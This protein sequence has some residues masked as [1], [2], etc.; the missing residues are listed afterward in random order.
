MSVFG[1]SLDSADVEAAVLAHLRA[2]MPT[3][4]PEIRRQKDPDGKLWPDGVEAIREYTVSHA[5]AVA[6]KW[7]E[8]QLPMLIA[9]SPGMEGDPYEQGDGT[10]SA[11]YGIAVTAIASGATQAD[12][13]ALARL[14]AS[15]A[16]MA[17][18]QEP[19]LAAGTDTPFAGGVAMGAERIAP[20]RRGVEAERNLLA[21]T[22]PFLIEVNEIL[23][24]N[25]GP[26][27]PQTAEEIAEGVEP[28]EWPDVKEGGGSVAIDQGADKVALLREGGFFPD[29]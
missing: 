27:K 5:Q 12:T 2:W 28:P 22:Y 7:P 26:L 17:M 9:E 25:G 1:P 29:L 16:R 24:V 3:T 21:V 20:V 6:H 18:L 19:S 10:V 23:N 13:K 14:Y 4:I 15:A 11:I 8:D